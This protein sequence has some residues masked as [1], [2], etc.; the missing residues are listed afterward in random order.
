MVE[1]KKIF[2]QHLV[3]LYHFLTQYLVLCDSQR[4]TWSNKNDTVER[5]KKRVGQPKNE[6]KG[7][8]KNGK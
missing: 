3:C 5:L 2:L 6:K 4:K 8:I 1:A 7:R